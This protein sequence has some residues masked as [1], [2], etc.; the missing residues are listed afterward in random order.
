MRD[1]MVRYGVAAHVAGLAAFLA[2]VCGGAR[3]DLLVAVPW[4][5]LGVLAMTLCCPA[6]RKGET[7]EV[8]RRRAAHNLLRDPFLY[9]GMCFLVFLLLQWLN[10]GRTL[11][12]DAAQ[13]GWRLAAARWGW[14]PSCV[15]RADVLQACCWAVPAFAGVLAI[16]HGMTRRGKVL[17]LQLL[18]GNGAL[19]AVAGLVCAL[20]GAKR[21][22]GVAA[23]TEPFFA[24]FPYV[25]HA[26]AFFVLLS[27]IA[28]GLLVQAWLEESRGRMVWLGV[29]LAGNLAGA[30]G[31]LS[32]AALFWAALLVVAGGIYAIRHAWHLVR[33]DQRFKV[34]I[35]LFLVVLA[36]GAFWLLAPREQPVLREIRTI[37]WDALE[38]E[39]FGA[40]APQVAFAWQ[41]W[42]AHPWFGVGSGGFAHY[43][44]LQV[45]ATERAAWHRGGGQVHNDFVQFLTEQGGVGFG[46]LLGA[47]VALLAPVIRRLRIAHRNPVDDWVG[48]HWLVF[49]ISPVTVLILAGVGAICLTSLLDLPFR[50]PAILVTWC[51]VLACAPAFLPAK[52]YRPPTPAPGAATRH[53][54]TG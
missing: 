4:L 19:L 32:R 51:F 52:E 18:V 16:R 25:N 9:L 14:A 15:D 48:E 46:L 54:T 22:L 41:L 5:S 12:L 7:L 42:R 45:D 47:V 2:W 28:L 13:G 24:S 37:P 11:L 38:R 23:A 1:E 50:S 21:I 34:L 39:T 8:A 20:V 3:T 33:A 36:A 31:S 10:G 49:R 44:A 26:G 29:A 17:L 30:I 27:A 35:A 43:A 40:R 53:R 6:L